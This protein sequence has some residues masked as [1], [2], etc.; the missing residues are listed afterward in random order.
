MSRKLHI[1]GQEESEGWEILNATPAPYV[2]H[3]CN[4]ND[5]SIFQDNTF[6]EIYASHVLEHFD[7]SAELEATLKE[8]LR[9]ME[10]GGKI[11]IS[12]PDL[13]VLAELILQKD[14]LTVDERFFVMRMMFGG[15]IDKYDYHVVGLNQDFLAGYL[16]NAGYTNLRRV[17]SF[18]LF[19]DTSNMQ[20]KET[21]ISL[22]I[23]AEKPRLQVSQTDTNLTNKKTEQNKPCPQD[24]KKNA[25]EALYYAVREVSPTLSFTILEIG[26]LPIEGD[27][28]PFHGLIDF[29]PESTLIAFEVDENL[30]NELNA[31]SKPNIHYYPV[32]VGQHDEER[33]F[34]NT[35][36]P[37]CGSLYK[38]NEKFLELYQ[39]L[40]VSMIQSTS[41]VN[42]VNLDNFTRENRINDVDFIKIDVQG[43]ELDIFKGGV[44]TLDKVI[45]IVSEVEFVPLYVDQPLF[46]DVCSQ[47]AKHDMMFHKFLGVAG[48]TLKPVVLNNDPNFCSQQM[49]ADAIFIKNINKLQDLESEKLLKLGILSYIYNSID[50]SYF[51]FK[52]H[53]DRNGTNLSPK[54]LNK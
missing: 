33:L 26:A 5:L 12:V 20:Y 28:E 45:S 51:C 29:F 14:K 54:A 34:Y 4:A 19:N 16:N 38:P 13:D 1:G 25:K 11:Y 47:L 43:A 15:H 53:D 41:T 49:W 39:N 2:T 18:G 22:N 17:N 37:M 8:W 48:R 44:Q 32:A 36:H 27:V 46:G 7:Y 50:L 24:Q 9:V 23:I 52:L 40:G 3:V 30:C 21:P 10:P 31:K 42:T 35:V 6:T